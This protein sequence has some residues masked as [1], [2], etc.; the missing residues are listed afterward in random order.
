MSDLIKL[1]N[2]VAKNGDIKA[3]PISSNMIEAQ[4]GKNG[5]GY[6]KIAVNN[7]SINKILLEKYTGILYLVS[8]EEFNN[9]R[10]ERD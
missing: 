1:N 6:V 3:F 8:I 5:W 4:T 2:I 9:E 10:L 7:E